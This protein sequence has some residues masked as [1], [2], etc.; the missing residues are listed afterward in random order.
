M[1]IPVWEPVLDGSEKKYVIDCLDTAWITSM[2]DYITRFEE[3]F[4][5]YCGVRH[6]IACSSGTTAIHLAIA[7]AGIRAG[8]EWNRGHSSS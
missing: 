4:A 8:G 2:G 1:V 6:G 7:S 3:S 5:R